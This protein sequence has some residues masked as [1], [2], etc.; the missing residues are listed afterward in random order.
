MTNPMLV[1]RGNCSG[2]ANAFIAVIPIWSPFTGF[3]QKNN[4]YAHSA[5]SCRRE[6]HC[7]EEEHVH[8]NEPMSAFLYGR[9]GSRVEK[10]FVAVFVRCV[11]HVKGIR[12]RKGSRRLFDVRSKLHRFSLCCTFVLCLWSAAVFWCIRNFWQELTSQT[13]RERRENRG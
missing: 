11:F 9:N 1:P 13:K 10:S 7:T 12:R 5:K 3:G 4:V 6:T 8:I 2:Q